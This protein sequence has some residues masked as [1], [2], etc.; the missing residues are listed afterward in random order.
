MINWA[1][2]N[3]MKNMLFKKTLVTQRQATHWEKIFA[4]TLCDKGLLTRTDLKNSIKRSAKDMDITLVKKTEMT[5]KSII[6][7]GSLSYN[8]R[9]L[10][11]KQSITTTCLITMTKIKNKNTDNTKCW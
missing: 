10:Q 3:N 1:S 11:T 6:N 8:I 4:K 2:L 5:K 7:R 9:E